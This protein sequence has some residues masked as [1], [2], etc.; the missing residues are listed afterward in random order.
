MHKRKIFLLLLFVIAT[1]ITVMTALR[2]QNQPQRQA[3]DENYAPVTDYSASRPNDPKRK[4][5]GK[6]YKMQ[7]TPIEEMETGVKPLPIISPWARGLSA[8]PVDRSDAIVKGEVTSAHAYLSEDGTGVYSEFTLKISE[9]FKGDDSIS[10]G[11][12]IVTERAGGAIRF[13]SGKVQRYSVDQQGMPRSGAQ[14]VLFLRRNAEDGDFYI[15]TGYE[16]RL[17]HVNP[18]DGNVSNGQNH[19]PFGVYK[20]ADETSFLNDLRAAIAN[21]PQPL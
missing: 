2:G 7:P 18:L 19:L 1:V 11:Q 8:L 5:K 21:A 10:L 16:L 14:Y 6:R 13:P 15:V 17:G 9:V 4:A 12:E 3:D 20:N